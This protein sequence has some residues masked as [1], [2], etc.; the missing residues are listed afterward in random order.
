MLEL[1]LLYKN[2]FLKQAFYNLHTPPFSKFIFIIKAQGILSTK[3][4][5]FIAGDYNINYKSNRYTY[6]CKTKSIF[7][8]FGLKLS[9][10]EFTRVIKDSAMLIIRLVE[11]GL[12]L[13]RQWRR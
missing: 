9:A 6:S 7:N 3:Y 4:L 11:R 5:F 8:L 12:E 13:L 1:K 10:C 2:I